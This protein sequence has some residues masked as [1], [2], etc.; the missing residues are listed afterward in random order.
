MNPGERFKINTTSLVDYILS[1]N[2]A[3]LPTVHLLIVK[4]FLLGS[5][6]KYLIE[7]F[8]KHSRHIW[9]HIKDS[10]EKYFVSNSKVIFAIFST[11][12]IDSI[13]DLIE[14]EAISAKSKDVIWKYFSSF[15]KISINYLLECRPDDK[16]VLNEAHMWQIRVR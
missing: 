10:D 9:G 7:L 4:G 14:S 3:D 11:D 15:V 8:I 1:L 2:A 12:K 5:D 6:P 13:V 16:R